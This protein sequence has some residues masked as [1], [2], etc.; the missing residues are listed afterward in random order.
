MPIA[1][2]LAVMSGMLLSPEMPISASKVRAFYIRLFKGLR[3]MIGLAFGLW[4]ILWAIPFVVGILTLPET[5]PFNESNWL[6][7]QSG[8]LTAD[9]A[10]VS[11]AS[12]VNQLNTDESIYATWNL[13]HIIY[14]LIER[15]ITC[16]PQY[17]TPGHIVRA[18]QSLAE[19]N[20]L[21]LLSS[22]YP[23]YYEEWDFVSYTVLAEYDHE[24]FSRPIQA[25]RIQYKP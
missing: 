1:A 7:Y 25:I 19:G 2:P 8:I 14:F 11:A 6:E 23:P 12:V 10:T 21:L 5:L 4:M 22:G 20:T 18:I 9:E 3:W 17:D 24:I 15:D 13:C 16:I